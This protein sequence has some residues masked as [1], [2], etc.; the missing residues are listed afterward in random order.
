MWTLA[1]DV[2]RDQHLNLTFFT[3]RSARSLAATVTV[4]GNG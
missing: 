3:L 4:Q 2:S 1:G